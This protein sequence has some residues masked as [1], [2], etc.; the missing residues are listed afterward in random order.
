MSVCVCAFVRPSVHPSVCSLFEVP[1]WRL[2]APTSQS[3][4]SK[5]EKKWSQIWKLLLIG[6]KITAQKELFF[7]LMPFWYW[8][9]S[10]R[11]TVFLPPTFQCQMSK[12]FRFSIFFGIGATIRIGQDLLCLPYSG[13][14]FITNILARLQ[15]VHFFSSFFLPKLAN[16]SGQ[17]LN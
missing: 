1:F 4:M 6:C 9:F 8:F 2:F 5:I 3:W 13:F 10:L 16:L 11:L 7:A 14:F 12:L 15:K 17:N